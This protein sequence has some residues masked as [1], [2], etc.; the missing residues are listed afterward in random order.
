MCYLCDAKGVGLRNASIS[1]GMGAGG[2]VS[3]QTSS[4]TFLFRVIYC[5]L[6]NQ[7]HT[8]SLRTLKERSGDTLK[9]SNQIVLQFIL[10]LYIFVLLFL[11]KFIYQ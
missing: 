6:V 11:H 4:H 5:S 7:L 1:F 3:F 8:E 9:C 10:L 2:W